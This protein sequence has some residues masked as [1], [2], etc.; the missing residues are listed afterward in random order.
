MRIQLP[1]SLIIDDRLL[2]IFFATL[3]TIAFIAIFGRR[4]W[5]GVNRVAN[6]SAQRWP[7]TIWYTCAP[8]AVALVLGLVAAIV[9]PRLGINKN[10]FQAQIGNVPIQVDGS[11]GVFTVV[12]LGALGFFSRFLPHE[13][14]TPPDPPVVSVRSVPDSNWPDLSSS[15]DST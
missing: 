5:R 9:W 3:G 1:D 13:P 12:F 15:N 11:A 7:R 10:S 14:Q 6:Y 4:I 2:G 8:I